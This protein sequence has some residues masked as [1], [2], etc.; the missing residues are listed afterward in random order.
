MNKKGLLFS[1]L[2]YFI[3]FIMVVVGIIVLVLFMNK[4][5]PICGAGESLGISITYE[6]C[7]NGKVCSDTYYD[8]D[9]D[10]CLLTACDIFHKDKCYY[11]PTG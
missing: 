5:I 2:N 7:C 9:K 1:I 4:F 11:K 8:A 6:K 3:L 10:L